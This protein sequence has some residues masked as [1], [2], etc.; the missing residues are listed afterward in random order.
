MCLTYRVAS[1]LMAHERCLLV[2]V[3]AFIALCAVV[4]AHSED[5]EEGSVEETA[6]AEQHPQSRAVDER[7]QPKHLA[8][9]TLESELDR[10]RRERLQPAVTEL[11]ITQ[12]KHAMLKQNM[13]WFP[14][15][16]QK[17]AL[18]ASEEGVKRA[19]QVVVFV[20]NKEKA[21]MARLKPLYGIVSYEFMQEQRST[22]SSAVAQV[23]KL[24][25]DNA[26]YQSLFDMGRRESIKDV[27]LMFFVQWLL[28][29]VIMYPFAAAYY[30]FWAL[31]WDIYAY[32]SGPTDVATGLMMWLCYAGLMVS[33]VAALVGGYWY[34]RKYHPGAFENLR[35]VRRRR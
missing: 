16:A 11:T 31:P 34:I 15:S 9:S 13:P 19:A 35:D 1:T 28:N 27:I 33:P 20:Q 6:E 5:V 3:I 12:Q 22:I 2:V 26:W 8:I 30:V 17:S 10:L 7:K 21:L 25:Y 14:S 23:N 32:S 18:Q 24:A 4:K 29:Y